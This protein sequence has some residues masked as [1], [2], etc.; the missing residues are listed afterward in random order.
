MRLS[1]LR[2]PPQSWLKT[3]SIFP[4]RSSQ[5]ATDDKQLQQA[6][7]NYQP[8]PGEKLLA[9]PLRWFRADAAP[10]GIAFSD[11]G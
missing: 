5:K 3:N 7:K 8:K 10:G 1:L 9:G 4:L 11:L 2:D 6:S